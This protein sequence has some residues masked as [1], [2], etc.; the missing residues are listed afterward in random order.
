[1]DTNVNNTTATTATF[2]NNSTVVNRTEQVVLTTSNRI[3]PI[4]VK[5]RTSDK[6]LYAAGTLLAPGVFNLAVWFGRKMLAHQIEDL[7]RTNK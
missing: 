4:K 2:D 5:I 3:E 7:P 1:M 6:L